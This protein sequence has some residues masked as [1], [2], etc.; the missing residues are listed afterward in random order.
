VSYSFADKLIIEFDRGL[1]TLSHNSV[2]T[3]RENPA[4]AVTANHMSADDMKLSARLMRVNHAGEVAAQGLYH[5]QAITAKNATTQANMDAAAREEGD[6]LAWCQ[7]RLNELNSHA[8]IFS[9]V[10]YLGSF[11]IGATAGLLG[12]KWSLGFVAETEAQVEEHL[13]DHLRRLP[14]QD[15]KSQ[16]IIQQMQQDEHEHGQT[17]KSLGGAELP[18]PAK[19]LMSSISHVMK[20]GAYWV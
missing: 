20:V 9:P 16:A 17:A 5:G 15:N 3:Q 7:E 19:K 11:A 1:R 8:S 4:K 2:R 18:T 6:H 14:A 13:Q 12:D 10:W